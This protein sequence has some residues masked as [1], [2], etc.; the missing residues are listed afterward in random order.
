MKRVPNDTG[1]VLVWN[2]T[3]KKISTR[4]VSEII[5]DLSLMTI[6]TNQAVHGLKTFISDGSNNW[7]YNSLRVSGVNGYAAGIAFN[8]YGGESGQLRF[9]LDGTF[10]FQNSEG[11]LYRNIKANAF[12]KYGATGNNLLKDD[13]STIAVQSLGTT[14][15]HDYLYHNGGNTAV[16]IHSVYEDSKFKYSENHVPSS[17]NMFPSTVNANAIISIG[18]HPGGYGQL[19][20]FNDIGEVY[21]KNVYAGNWGNWR[22]F[23][24]KD[25]IENFVPYTGATQNFD[26]NSK[27]ISNVNRFITNGSIKHNGLGLSLVNIS[28]SGGYNSVLIR[29]GLTS[30]NMG[31]F[32]V[33]LYTYAHA[34]YEFNVNN[35]KYADSNY[36]TNITWKAGNSEDI[37]RIEF[38]KDSNNILYVNIVM[39]LAYPRLAVTDLMAYGWDDVPFDSFNWGAEFDGNTSSLINEGQALPVDFRRDTFLTSSIPNLLAEKVN[40]SGDTMTGGLTA[41]HVILSGGSLLASNFTGSQ[42]L[43][44]QGNTLYLGNTS[45]QNIQIESGELTH[46]K[47]GVGAGTIWTSHNF[48]PS[49]YIPSSEKGQANGVATLD[50]GGKVPESQLP[51]YVDDVL[52]FSS[53]SSF[54]TVGETGKIYVSTDTNHTYRWSGST[55]IQIASGAVQ[56]VNGQTGIVNLTRT[57]VGLG[58]VDNTADAI[59]NV[60]TA[61]SLRNVNIS[62][63]ELNS[64]TLEPGIYN[65]EGFNPGQGLTA[66][67]HYIIQLGSYTAGGYRAQIAIP[68]SSGTNDSMYIR[69][70]VAGNWG[71][72]ERIAKNSD[73]TAAIN[74]LN[75][76]N[77][78]TISQLNEKVSKSGD[79]MTGM[80][81]FAN[82]VGGIMGNIGDNDYWRVYGNTAGSNQGYLEI[83]T[84]DD[85]NEP[86]Y[87]R[88]YSGVFA[89]IVRTATILDESGNTNFPNTVYSGNGNSSEWQSAY[90]WGN[91][92]AIGNNQWLGSDYVG[93][94]NEKPNSSY[95]GAGK[96]KLQMLNG[97]N[98]NSGLGWSDVLWLS[99]Y[100]G[101]DVKGSTALWSDKSNNRIG[102]TKQDYDATDWGSYYE[103]WTSANLPNPATQSDLSNYVPYNGSSQNIDI[104]QKKLG[105]ASLVQSQTFN[106][107]GTT[108]TP[109]GKVTSES[110]FYN[111]GNWGSGVEFG[112]GISTNQ[113][114]GLDIMANQGGQSIRFWAGNDN[115]NPFYVARFYK[116]ISSFY[117]SLSIDNGKEIRLKGSNDI[118]HSVK[119]FSDDYDGFA[120]S[121]GFAVK[122]Y[123]TLENLFHVTGV[124]FG[125]F[126]QNVEAGGFLKTGSSNDYVLLGQGD[127]RHINNFYQNYN[128]TV[129]NQSE[130]IPNGNQ[131]VSL[132]NSGNDFD[133]DLS[134]KTIEGTF[135]NFNAY[136]S[137]SK[138]LG[139]TLFARTSTG[140]GI[141]YKTWYGG[142]QQE[143]RRLIDSKD[144]Q[145]YATVNQLN[146]KVNSFE[147]AYALGF[148]S[149]L[150]TGAPYIYHQ[151]DGYVFLAT[152]SFIAQ[153]YAL[154]AGSNA[155]DTWVNS[156]NGLQSNPTIMGKMGNSGGQ[157]NL[158]DATWGQVAG[159][160][161]TSGVSQGN[162][163]D[164]WYYRIKMLH[165]NG[166]GYNGEIAVQMTGGNSLQYR[167]MENGV[168]SGWIKTWDE[169]NF[170]PL[171]YATQTDLLNYVSIYTPQTII[172][173]K[174]FTGGTGNNYYEAALEVRGNGSTV[175]PGISFHQPGLVASQIRMDASG[176]ICI[177]DNPGS[178][179]ENFRAKVITG[180]SFTSTIHGNSSQWYDAYV[181]NHK[182]YNNNQY[183]GSDYI[184]GFEKPNSE[185]F[186]GGKVKLQMLHGANVGAPDIWNDALWI[187]SYTGADVKKS[188]AIISSKYSNEIGFVKA[189]F[190]S[191]KWEKYIKFWTSDNLNPNDFATQAWVNTNFIPK[192][193]PVYNITQANINSWNAAAGGSS[194]THSNLN[195]LNNINQWLGVG[196][197]P[198]FTNVNLMNNIGYGH[199]VFGEDNIGG[200]IGIVDLSNDR[201]YA[202]R[203]NEYLKYGSSVNDFEGLNIHFDAKLLSIGKEVTNDEDKVQLAGNISVDTTNVYGDDMQLILN[204]LYNTDGNVRNSRNAH[205]YIVT[206]GTVILPSKPILGQRIEIFNYSKADIEVMHDNVGTMFILQGFQKITGIVGGKGFI[207]DEK[208][209]YA[210]QYDI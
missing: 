62:L 68:Y 141:Y 75:L 196:Q 187:S 11:N 1:S 191:S 80:I 2:S 35:Y 41:P 99:S 197:S 51:S 160:I 161:N 42:I 79:T 167:R 125:K 203:I 67:Y 110:S 172:A 57:D 159:Y 129:A 198:S 192:S 43:S 140:Q 128:G 165:N 34:Y 87:V 164:D 44:G 108:T 38:L 40:K 189:D 209:V 82:N 106:W 54:P 139:F 173:Q 31:T 81:N 9:A 166:A 89:N 199:L 16:D 201:F 29:T 19:I 3:T 32:T 116:D 206:R 186:G 121:S 146:G 113:G 170:N 152:Q 39:Y 131:W 6:N 126:A 176:Q 148:S 103:F 58:N 151:T 194:H 158:A 137:N 210:K 143:W 207:F 153:N 47:N 105:N 78:A 37:I 144:I 190:D 130:L 94:G 193:H 52:E 135:A 53:L 150:S 61:G 145:S 168:D 156:S 7:T 112:Y 21:S 102:F 205:I 24:F 138:N 119:N 177:I 60:A 107:S 63:A 72:W 171:N 180:E 69:T 65:A 179:Y 147:N 85:G 83:A 36:L 17:P 64:L 49:N 204:P 101:S 200:E 195:L 84:G 12:V 111:I 183:L 50:N 142:G 46:W 59:K 15:T 120:V 28:G 104:N 33:K 154:R 18:K 114:G 188:T 55:Y 175:I 45:L 100:V 202:G 162:P 77:Y 91:H 178:S 71:S 90:I 48:T 66:D 13:G 27:N 56:S 23:V 5:A 174:V 115:D 109:M 93:G 76:S 30:G 25:Q 149:G 134:N 185:Y 182:N 123:S 163:T 181:N 98:V 96:L 155:T 14:H 26:V 4:T 92:K 70:A 73:I 133:G 208:P 136:D 97:G 127:H 22:Q 95:F 169:K 8:S 86:I 132:G 184:G 118:A 20:G 124:G 88:Q 122:N 157:S 10:E 74:A 117:S